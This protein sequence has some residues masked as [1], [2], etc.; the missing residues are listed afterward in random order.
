MTSIIRPPRR[1]TAP[2][3]I[4]DTG[5][6]LNRLV[7]ASPVAV[8]LSTRSDARY[9]AAND[10]Y[11]NLVGYSRDEMIGYTAWELNV[12]LSAED[13]RRLVRTIRS[14]NKLHNL[15]LRLRTRSGESP[16][17]FPQKRCCTATRNASCR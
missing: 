2:R 11:L 6:L 14:Q 17:W 1:R 9:L 10:E 4:L 13:R 7:E 5:D 12:W 16:P 3:K 8:A 15:E